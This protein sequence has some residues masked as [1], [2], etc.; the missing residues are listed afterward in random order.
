MEKCWLVAFRTDHHK[1]CSGDL[2]AFVTPG[3]TGSLLDDDITRLD[4]FLLAIVQLQPELTL[5][6]DAV[7]DGGRRMHAGMV[8]FEAF[9]QAGQGAAD[10]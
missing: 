3:V 10:M 5:K 8:R 4:P 1:Q 7:V 6:Q 2:I 9:E